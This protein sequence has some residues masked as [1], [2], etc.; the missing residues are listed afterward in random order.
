MRM[1]SLILSSSARSFHSNERVTAPY[2]SAAQISSLE[3]GTSWWT[4][5][6]RPALWMRWDHSPCSSMPRPNSR[7][8]PPTRRTASAWAYNMHPIDHPYATRVES[9]YTTS[10]FGTGLLLDANFVQQ[11]W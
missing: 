3:P 1:V 5:E 6:V 2:S 7:R 4:K 9:R 11:Y 8:I 10:I